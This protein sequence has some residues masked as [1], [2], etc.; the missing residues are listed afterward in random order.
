MDELIKE[1]NA[2]RELLKN[3][4]SASDKLDTQDYLAFLNSDDYD[5]YIHVVTELD[6]LEGNLRRS[7]DDV[8]SII[9][10]TK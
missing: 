9:R 6:I 4:R 7:F 5:R 3:V 10:R 1:R 2:I 8:M